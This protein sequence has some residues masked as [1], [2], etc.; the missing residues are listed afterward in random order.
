MKIEIVIKHL[1]F[2]LLFNAI[3]LSV[4]FLISLYYKENSALPPL[5]YTALI[6]IILGFFP[7]IFVE[8]TQNISFSEGLSIVVFGWLLTC[9][10]GM[11][12]Y[13]M[14]GGEFTLVNAW[15]ESV[16]GYTTTGSTVLNNI[17]ALPKG[18]LFWRSST[19]WM[20]GLGIILFVLLVLPQSQNKKINIYNTEIS[21]LSKLNFR[22]RTRQIVNILALVY[23]ILTITETIMLSLFGMNLFDAVNHSFATIATGGFS[24]RNMSIASYNNLGIEIT[25]IIFMIISSLHFGLI[26]GTLSLKKQ[27]IF[28][29]K[30][31][32]MF[33]LVMLIGI[34]LVATK[35]YLDDYFGWWESLR[36][37][38]FQVVSVG[39][40][41]G[42]A[43]IDTANWPIF[44]IMILIYFTIQCGMVGSTSGGLK[45]DRVYLF[46][47]SVGKQLKMMRHP[48]AIFS[49][50]M[51]KNLIDEQ[52]EQNTVVFISLYIL[53]F[54][55]TSVLLTAMDVDGISAFSA[56]IAT[57]GNVGP[58]FG[59][60]SSLGNFGTL[61]D[62][63]KIILSINMLLGRLEIFNIFAILMIKK[64]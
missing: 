17:E 56:S 33:I 53:T 41:T 35:L 3:F 5:L 37:A 18:L 45:F 40:T 50:R 61:P 15:F 8:R 49:L 20:G 19:H 22:Y 1:G 58:G 47:K 6:C 55:I 31:V 28:T 46:I 59:N 63:A 25:I 43:T 13:L 9:I 34:I 27:N 21:S 39:T 32:R 7:L 62:L 30:V 10:I 42:F 23:L 2:V 12:P 52:L 26:F 51:D 38:A 36:H 16:S 57:I 4:S 44:S 64:S 54:F 60:V 14:W 11:L 29:S 48:N 24:T